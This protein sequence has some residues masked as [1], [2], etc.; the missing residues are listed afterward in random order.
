MNLKSKKNSRISLEE[1]NRELKE[2]DAQIDQGDF[3]TQEEVEKRSKE[4]DKE[5]N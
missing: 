1:Y 4:W 5:S 3:Y 2:A